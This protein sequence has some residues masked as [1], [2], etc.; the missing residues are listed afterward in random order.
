MTRIRKEQIT[1][2]AAG[3]GQVLTADGA[4]NVAFEAIPA[5]IDANAIHDNVASEISAI[6]EK[7]TPVGADL[8]IIEDSAASYVK[9][10]A[11][12]G[13]LPGGGGA[14]AFTDLSDVPPDYTSDGGKLVRVKTTED[15]LEFISPPSGSGDVVG[16]SSA[17]NGNLAVFDGTTGKVIKDGGAPGGGST[18]VLMVQVFS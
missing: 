18:D 7:A 3:D 9:K 5:Q 10:K 4:G 13:N 15:G 1:S 17:V 6:T 12:I 11:Q 8:V 2:G 16:P 14:G